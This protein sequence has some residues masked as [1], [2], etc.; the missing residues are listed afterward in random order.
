MSRVFVCNAQDL[1][2]N[3]LQGFDV[4]GERVLVVKSADCFHAYQGTCPHQEV[5]LEDG[6]FDGEVLTCHQHLWQWN[7]A[8]GE[9][10]G[11][12]ET[13]LRSFRIERDGDKLF[14]VGAPTGEAG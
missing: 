1:P 7:I 2:V 6:F 10:V 13:P 11:L 14:V 9:P 3:G 12:A 4:D 5:L 8:T